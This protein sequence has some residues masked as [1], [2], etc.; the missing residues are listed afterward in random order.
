RGP[1]LGHA[2]AILVGAGRTRGRAWP[3]PAPFPCLIAARGHPIFRCG[4]P[5]LCYEGPWLVPKF[6]ACHGPRLPIQSVDLS[7]DTSEWAVGSGQIL[8]PSVTVQPAGP[9][10]PSLQMDRG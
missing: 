2:P 6:T 8:P 4:R 7:L 1:G 9:A 10:V 3:A 5:L